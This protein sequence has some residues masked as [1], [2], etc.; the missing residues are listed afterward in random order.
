MKIK[1]IK[2]EEREK[3]LAAPM[4]SALAKQPRTGDNPGVMAMTV[5]YWIDDLRQKREN[6]RLTFQ[7]LFK[8]EYYA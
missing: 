6:E 5:K 2:R 8:E 4:V 3:E 1:I 7:K